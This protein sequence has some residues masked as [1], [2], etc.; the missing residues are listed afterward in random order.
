[1]KTNNT[2]LKSRN[3]SVMAGIDKHITTSITLDGTTFTQADLKDQQR[4]Q[5]INA[6][7]SMGR[8]Y[9]PSF[10]RWHS[11][12]VDQLLKFPHGTFD[13]FVDTLALIGLGLVKQTPARRI[14]VIA[15]G[16]EPYTLGWIK[17]NTK[18]AERENALSGW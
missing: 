7:M 2:T 6:R 10:A 14:K 12:A 11:D 17:A 9:F 4:A 16:P 3:T 5:A 15:K 8:V 13:D 18:R 1:M